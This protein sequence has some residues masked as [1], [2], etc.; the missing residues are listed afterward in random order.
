MDQIRTEIDRA[1]AGLKELLRHGG[2]GPAAILACPQL[3]ALANSGA[4]RPEDPSAA[5]RGIADALVRAFSKLAQREEALA[6]FGM[7][8]STEGQ[9]LMLRRAA[10][11]DAVGVKP[12]SFRQRREPRLLDDLARALVVELPGRPVDD[13]ASS[14]RPRA[15]AVAPVDDA[16]SLSSPPRDVAEFWQAAISDFLDAEADHSAEEYAAANARL[17][18][19][20]AVQDG[21]ALPPELVSLA[22][23]ATRLNQAQLDHGDA[24]TTEYRHP[25][26]PALELGPGHWATLGA[27]Y[28]VGLEALRA[29]EHTGDTALSAIRG[30]I[31]HGLD[32]HE[33]GSGTTQALQSRFDHRR[34]IAASVLALGGAA[35]PQPLDFA[36]ASLRQRGGN[37][38]IETLVA[39]K[40]AHLLLEGV[41]H[42]RSQPIGRLLRRTASE[43]ESE[44]QQLRRSIVLSTL[45]FVAC[46]AI[47][48]MF[49]T[50]EERIAIQDDPARARRLISPGDPMWI[51]RQVALLSLYRRADGYRLLGERERAYNDYRKLQRIGLHSR[52]GIAESANRMRVRNAFVD[53]LDA[54][55]AYRIGTLYASDHDYARAL[56]HLSEGHKRLRAAYPH[57]GDGQ[58]TAEPRFE[59][60]ELELRLAQGSAYFEAGD[61]KR[62]LKWLVRA[63]GSLVA[64]SHTQ[65]E[66]LAS[67]RPD[68]NAQGDLDA[69]L[70]RVQRESELD[71]LGLAAF[72]PPV[73]DDMCSRPVPRMFQALAADVL[74]RIGRVLLIIGLPDEGAVRCLT[75]AADLD[76][77]NLFVRTALLRYR[78]AHA[79]E[80]NSEDTVPRLIASGPGVMDC[81]PTGASDVDQAIRA[82]VHLMLESLTAAATSGAEDVDSRVARALIGRFLDHTDRVYLRLEVINQYLMRPRLEFQ[83]PAIAEPPS[84]DAYLELMSLRGVTPLVPRA[85]D[86]AAVGGGYL[87]RI[88][89]PSLSSD[90]YQ[91][92]F[93]VLVDPGDGV[94]DSLYRQGLGIGDID[95]VI[96]TQDHPDQLAGLDAVLSLREAR[97]P[98]GGEPQPP[99]AQDNVL[100]F[101]NQSVVQRYAGRSQVNVRRLDDPYV[102][103][104]FP[105]GLS[106]A[107]LP[108][109]HKDLSGH[110]AVP[111]VLT[112]VPDGGAPLRVTFMADTATEAIGTYL[113]EHRMTS[114]ETVAAWRSALQSDI[115]V[116]QLNDVSIGEL[117][118]IARLRASDI[119]DLMEFDEGVREL[120]RLGREPEAARLMRALSLIPRLQGPDRPLGLLEAG[121]LADSA[122]SEHLHLHGLL[123]VAKEMAGVSV[124]A[125]NP[126]HRVL[127]VSERLEQLGSF[128]GT[129]AAEINAQIFGSHGTT[130]A[131]TADSGLRIRLD[132]THGSRVLCS[133]CAQNN[134]R[135][136]DERFHPPDRIAELRV[137]GNYESH[138]WICS[139]HH[140]SDSVRAPAFV[141][142]MGAYD[143]FASG[144]RYHG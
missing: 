23:V 12:D 13:G 65:V 90:A 91:C 129:I 142:Q 35:V 48:W 100:L 16:P 125:L 14:G 128:R 20:A 1:R 59:R 47:P 42:L 2:A 31:V 81:W 126:H 27:F 63:W 32:E 52:A 62:A 98:R 92:V 123:A 136:D 130:T 37:L 141:A 53:V 93:N 38:M 127:V 103:S 30:A 113:D 111:F 74:G 5:A 107:P 9:R 28:D 78:L 72:L 104:E 41:E 3:L 56:V 39:L 36:L 95:M 57:R 133:V 115:V 15:I 17:R 22:E 21:H 25:R 109:V 69:Y 26:P 77:H 6:L 19:I 119:D 135:L 7:S 44:R 58:F 11:A 137:R 24:V 84:T 60:L 101:G 118:D 86:I 43:L 120:V 51:A 46:N 131:L 82:G 64:L 94:V 40:E 105:P 8:P 87:V 10:A 34:A 80:R 144:G 4:A 79:I 85:A 76:P 61:M 29:S 139:P 114:I 33:P 83:R 124:E 71:R 110:D 97:K 116:A 102:A 117:R 140:P 112:F 143:P 132:E 49:A 134:D 121:F 54:L 75:H 67:S 66:Q 99:G 88:C 55:A 122:G 45:T 138:H 73:V 70:E 68:G 108:G 96:A 89:S 106:L 18:A 50:D